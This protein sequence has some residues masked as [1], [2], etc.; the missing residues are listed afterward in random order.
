MVSGK[1]SKGRAAPESVDSVAQGWFLL[2]YP[3]CAS[4]VFGCVPSV[5]QKGCHPSKYLT[6]MGQESKAGKGP[7]L[8]VGLFAK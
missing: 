8:L 6:Q 2:R 5:S 4:F 1:R 7:S 3:V